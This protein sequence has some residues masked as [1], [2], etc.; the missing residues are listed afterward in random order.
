M[1]IDSYSI[2]GP[3]ATDIVIHTCAYLGLATD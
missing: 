2:I 1:H 3:V